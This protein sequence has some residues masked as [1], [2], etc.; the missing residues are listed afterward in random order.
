MDTGSSSTA[1]SE[2]ATQRSIEKLFSRVFIA[3]GV[4]TLFVVL[5]DKSSGLSTPWDDYG[6]PITSTLYF[7][8]GLIIY[9][10]PQWLTAGILLSMIPTSIYEHGVL[11]WAIH[12]PST[13]SYY[14]AAASGPFFPLV[15]IVMFIALPRGAATYSWIHCAGFYV[16]FVLNATFLADPL[17][18]PGR[19][20]GEHVLTAVMMAHPVYIIALS[21]IVR[22]RERLHET[23]QEAFRNK[24]SFLGIM[25]HEIRNLLQTMVGS[26]DL[27]D[28]KLKDPAE[29]RYVD[30]LRSAANQLQTYLGD[31][32]QL[33][34]LE[35]PSLKIE[36]SQV[37]LTELLNDLRDEWLP[38][39]ERVGLQ[40]V[41][42]IS[43]DEN[44]EPLLI[45]TDVARLR[46]IISNLISNGLKYTD[47]G[48]ITL[49]A[50]PRVESP[51]GAVLTVA[52]TGIGIEE[53]FLSRIFEPYVRLKNAVG[54]RAE[55]S[56]LGLAIVKR[57]VESIG[58]SLRV[59]SHLNQGTRFEIR[60]P[61]VLG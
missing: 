12:F 53:H 22:L 32:N 41:V 49:S 6:G 27:L 35:D 45:Q 36:V 29:R 15:Y 17:S 10:R 13:A 44:G 47:V 37:D 16:Q 60:L 11:Y 48:G 26:V 51:G 8:S 23:R 21:Y 54:R 40:L 59:E 28:R 3:G 18:P 20:E 56:G 39:A 57:L 1:Q 58:G 14:S 4:G 24:E 34:R 30:R 42:Q 7:I 31:V 33:T 55:G 52:D 38:Q 50:G 5:F 19:V 43:A 25:S 9:F 46:Q 61:G 2:Q